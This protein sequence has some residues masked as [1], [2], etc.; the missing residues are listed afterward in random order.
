MGELGNGDF[1][2]ET[3]LL[4]DHV[5]TATVKAMIPSTLLRLTRRD[6]IELAERTPEVNERLAQARAE[7]ER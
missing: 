5:R 3:G 1:F 4:S 2:G 6:I 7:R